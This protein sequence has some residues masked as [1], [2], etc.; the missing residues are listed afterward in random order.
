M[1][2]CYAKKW[3]DLLILP[4]FYRMEFRL[5]EWLGNKS[6][7]RDSRGFLYFLGIA[8]F[9]PRSNDPVRLYIGRGIVADEGGRLFARWITRCVKWIP[10]Y[11]PYL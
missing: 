4:L 3:S 6:V 5:T 2:R 1:H 11:D 9:D 8:C 7:A 10:R